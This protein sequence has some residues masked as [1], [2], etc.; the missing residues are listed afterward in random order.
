MKT[1]KPRRYYS[2]AQFRSLLP[3]RKNMF[4]GYQ[5]R[6]EPII[7]QTAM[8]VAEKVFWGKRGITV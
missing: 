7:S 8:R 3:A 4:V 2:K 6:A 5:D 1:K